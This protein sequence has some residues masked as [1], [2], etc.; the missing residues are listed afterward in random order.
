[1]MSVWH[2]RWVAPVAASMDALVM[3]LIAG[4]DR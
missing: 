4:G 2:L 3:A 1:M